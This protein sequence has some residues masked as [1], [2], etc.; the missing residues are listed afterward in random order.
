[1]AEVTVRPAVSTEREALEALQIRASLSNPGDR[2]ALLAHP[3]AITLPLQQIID[4][5]VLVAERQGRIAG[6][7]VV[8]PRADG[9]AELDGL[10]VDPECWRKGTGRA[11][12]EQSACAARSA[13]ARYLHVVG[14]PHAEGFY[15][16]CGF[17]ICGSESTQFG[18]G[19]LLKRA[20]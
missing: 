3:E 6:F 14:N 5:R 20:L 4:G 1:M 18:M 17:Q 8:L 12:I 13:G 10:F 2:D 15:T 19:L 7:S 16:A 9:D 11:L